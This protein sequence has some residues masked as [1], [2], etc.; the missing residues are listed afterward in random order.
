M[1]RI[2][3]LERLF[4][5]ILKLNH[6][7]KTSAKELAES[8]EVNI[9]TIYRDI[10][11]LSQMEVPIVAHMG[12]NGGY[13]L[14]NDFFIS[15]IIFNRDE[16]F[17]LLL[18]QKLIEAVG[19]P[20]YKKYANTAFLK[21]KDNMSKE[22]FDELADIKNR[23]LFDINEKNNSQE[24]LSF[25]EVIKQSLENNIKIKIT[26]FN[27][28]KME[29]TSRVIKPYGLKY[30]D[31]A[32][33]IVAFC[34]LREELRIFR[35]RRIRKAFLSNKKFSLPSEFNIDD[36]SQE[37][38]VERYS[39]GQEKVRLSFKV[40]NKIYHI[41]KEYNY[42]S[43]AKIN[44]KTDDYYLIELKTTAPENY[45]KYCFDFYDGLEIISPEWLRNKVKIEIEKL[46]KKY[47]IV[48]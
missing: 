30:S 26:Y 28:H 20:G 6:S 45:I 2:N 29:T 9:R 10:E 22:L 5:I 44:K 38:K 34:E 17:T 24:N 1:S 8:F 37:S 43:N 7:D 13:S 4:A 11:A 31:G 41:I 39:Q 23:I 40:T 15:P 47:K 18:S 12:K 46:A 32:W 33:Y 14:L 19:M 16:I 3:K 25:F 36:F 27:P 48:K 35:L 21:I 42:F